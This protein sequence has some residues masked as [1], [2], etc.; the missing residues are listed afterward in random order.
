MKAITYR[1]YGSPDVLKLEEIEKP[2]PKDD[3]VLVKVFAS[4][5]NRADWYMLKGEPFMLRLE[6]GIQK[7]KRIILGADIAGQVEAVGK[8][9][10]GFKIGDDVFGDISACGWGGFAE[11][12]SVNENALAAKPTQITFEAAASAPMASVTALQG[13]RDKGQ[14]HQ[15][16]NVMIYGAS[17][18]VGT[19]AVQIAKSF[20][21][22]VTA[23]C[24]TRNVEMVRSLGADVVIDYTKEDFSQNGKVYDLILGANGDRSLADYKRALSPNGIYVCTGGSMKQIFSSLI[25]GNKQVRNLAS[26]PNQKDLIFIQEFLASGKIKAVIDKVYP[27]HELADAFRYF[28]TGKVKGKVVIRH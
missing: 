22:H 11:Y 6:A 16:Q 28:E 9:V 24:S 5:I 13:L 1:E 12:V 10:K 23:V 15:N 8:N 26:K 19:W 18:G 2:T 17:G 3:Q 20:G 14:I 4:S 21:T 25:F 7:P 27:L